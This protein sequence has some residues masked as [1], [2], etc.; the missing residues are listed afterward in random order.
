MPWCASGT[1]VSRCTGPFPPYSR[2]GCD[3]YLATIALLAAA[4]CPAADIT[5]LRVWP[6]WHTAATRSKAST[7][8]I[9]GKEL[10]AKWTVRCAASRTSAPGSTFLVRVKNPG[11]LER[12]ANF[13]VRVI[14]PDAPQTKVYNFPANIKA[15]SWLYEGDRAHGKRLG[16]GAASTRVA[17]DVELQTADGGPWWRGRRASLYE[18][19]QQRKPGAGPDEVDPSNVTNP[20][21][22]TGLEEFLLFLRRGWPARTRSR[23]PKLDRIPRPQEAVASTSGRESDREGMLDARLRQVRLGK[24]AL[25]AR[26]FRELALSGAD[27]RRCAWEDLTR[28]PGIGIKT[29]KFFVLHSRPGQMHGVLDTHVLGW[30]RDHWEPG[31]GR[32]SAVPRHSPQDPAHYRFWETVYFDA[33]AP[34]GHAAPGRRLPVSTSTSGA[35]RRQASPGRRTPTRLNEPGSPRRWPPALGAARRPP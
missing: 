27:L 14:S 9:F 7:N 34:P 15:G 20:A 33:G 30:M 5:V 10:L 35:A 26:S 31:K 16:D 24:Y 4:S 8:T 32:S 1:E 23:P 18:K 21:R 29:A 3:T 2:C 13:V 28:F 17:W 6:L 25:L 19:P 12:G 22:P 11:A